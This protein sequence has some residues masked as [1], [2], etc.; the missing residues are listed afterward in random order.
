MARKS[1]RAPRPENASDFMGPDANKEAIETLSKAAAKENAKAKKNT[2]E[3]TDETVGMHVNLIKAAEENWREAR[4]RAAELQGVLRNR[5]KV[6]KNDGVDIDALKLA[7]RIAERSS[8]E[9][10]AEQRS[11]GRY[12]RIMGVELGHQWAFQ[13]DEPGEGRPK[14]DANLQGQ[15]AGKNGEP[16]ENNPFTPGTEDFTAWAEGWT[17]G[18]AMLAGGIGKAGSGAGA[19]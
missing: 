17:T 8:G 2:G 13:F 3:V 14:V 11:V 9:V 7:L 16:A 15:H 19:H 18:Q 12:L 4:D 6:A 1:K 5:F 10:V